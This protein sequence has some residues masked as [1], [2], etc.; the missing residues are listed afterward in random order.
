M[1][2]TAQVTA[3]LDRRRRI[4]APPGSGSR[5]PDPRVRIGEK[6]G[7]HGQR[8]GKPHLVVIAR[9]LLGAELRQVRGDEL[10][11]QQPEAAK[12]QSRDEVHQGH[13]RG[14]PRHAEHA[15]AEE[16]AAD[17]HAVEAADQMAVLAGFHRVG[18]AELV[19]FAE[20]PLD[21]RVDPGV[22]A[23][24]GGLGAAGDGG[25]EVLIDR[26]GEGVRQHG[27]GE[28]ARQMEAVQRQDAAALR[29]QPV[30]AFAATGLRHREQAVSVG[31]QHE[32]S[33]DL[34]RAPGHAAYCGVGWPVREGTLVGSAASGG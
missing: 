26:D 33:R 18:V 32:V 23:T 4:S 34:N 22:V 14:V 3:R 29:V 2:G 27:A 17:R 7:R 6:T 25:G 10:G 31:P 1:T 20:Q 24:G 8:V 19:Q 21:L 5:P 30:E 9:Q 16:H 15:L 13:L 28:P 11:V 12:A